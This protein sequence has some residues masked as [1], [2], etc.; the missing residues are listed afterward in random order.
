MKTYIIYLITALISS[1]LLVSCESGS[2]YAGDP[3]GGSTGTGGSMARF[4]I[5]DDVLYVVDNATLK[6][7]NIAD[8]AKPIYM[9]SRDEGLRQNNLETIFV[10]DTLLF[11]GSQTGMYIY[12]VSIPGFPEYLSMA[13]HITSCDP[14]VAS[15]NY[16]YVTLNTE[17][18]VCGRNTNEIRVYDISNPKQPNLDA[19]ISTSSQHPK[20]LGISGNNLFVCFTAG[21]RVYDLTQPNA[22]K[23]VADL[24]DISINTYDVIPI[25]AHLMVTGAD[26]FYQFEY[27]DAATKLSLLSKIAVSKEN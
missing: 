1:F 16:A 14:V 20:G 12:N 25:G 11:I 27:D 9:P 4:T 8:A 6:L 26:G 10:M 15:G 5:K 24:E 7:F 19:T 18:A 13:S 21:L 22:P 2:D 3:S 17:N 23:W